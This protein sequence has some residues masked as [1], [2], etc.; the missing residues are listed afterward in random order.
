MENHSDFLP[1]QDLFKFVDLHTYTIIRGG[2]CNIVNYGK[3]CDIDIFSYDIHAFCRSALA[4]FNRLDPSEDWRVEVSEVSKDQLHVDFM[5]KQVLEIRLD[6]YGAFPKYKKVDIR[7]SLFESVL[8]NSIQITI[9]HCPAVEISIPGEI[10]D[11]LLRYIEYVEYY[12]LRPDKLKHLEYIEEK[13]PKEKNR[14]SLF[15]TKLHYYTDMPRCTGPTINSPPVRT[16]SKKALLK[17]LLRRL[18]GR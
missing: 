13:L 4:F 16:L 12:E 2:E 7:S 18:V 15:F 5:W 1:L 6:L 3:Q 10:D 14:K 8:E 9:P 17:I 11:L